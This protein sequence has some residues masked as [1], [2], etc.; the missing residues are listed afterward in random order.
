MDIRV[1]GCHGSQL[2][3][4]NVTGFLLDGTIMVDGG[5]ITSV[6]SMEEQI[7][8]NSILVTHAHLDHVRDIML[9]VDN[10]YCRNIC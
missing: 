6:L 7:N 5:T 9:L 10:L 1:S 2:P 8:I 3:G 4:Y